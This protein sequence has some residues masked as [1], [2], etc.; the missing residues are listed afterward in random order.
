MYFVWIKKWRMFCALHK[1]TETEIAFEI[2]TIQRQLKQNLKQSISSG[3]QKEDFW[4][5]I[6]GQLRFY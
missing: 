1:E 6:I 5:T 2:D 4:I 3:Q